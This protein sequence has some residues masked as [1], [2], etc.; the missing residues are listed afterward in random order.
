MPPHL[1]FTISKDVDDIDRHG[2]VKT[3]L[4]AMASAEVIEQMAEPVLLGQPAALS[5][6]RC[7]QRDA[8]CEHSRIRG[9]NRSLS[10][11]GA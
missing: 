1:S 8:L 5:M 3:T 4:M 10:G 2:V 7:C 11:A 6:A 9:D